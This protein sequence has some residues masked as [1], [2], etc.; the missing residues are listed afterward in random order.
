MRRQATDTF[1][2][3]VAFSVAFSDTKIAIVQVI[4]VVQY[5]DQGVSRLPSLPSGSSDP[6]E[7]RLLALRL[8]ALGL[9]VLVCAVTD[10]PS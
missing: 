9:V 3:S 4:C 6:P 8:L 7:S 10:G 1:F 2:N 5:F